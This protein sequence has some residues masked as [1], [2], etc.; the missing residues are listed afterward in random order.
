MVVSI[1]LNSILIN[2]NTI[3]DINSSGALID[4][5][6]STATVDYW[7]YVAVGTGVVVGVAA[8]CV[9]ISTLYVKP[10]VTDTTD[11]AV[12]LARANAEVNR[13]MR[14]AAESGRPVK[15]MENIDQN[16]LSLK[17]NFQNYGERLIYDSFPSVDPETMNH[18]REYILYNELFTGIH[19]ELFNMCHI[20]GA[21]TMVYC[22]IMNNTLI[23][24][25]DASHT[26]L[27]PFL[28][29]GAESVVESAQRMEELKVFTGLTLEQLQS[30]HGSAFTYNDIVLKKE[31][32][33]ELR[34]RTRFD[35]TLFLRQLLCYSPELRYIDWLNLEVTTR[36]A[37]PGFSDSIYA[38]SLP[39]LEQLIAQKSGQFSSFMSYRL[40]S[41]SS[42]SFG[43]P[44]S[45]EYAQKFKQALYL[46]ACKPPK[47]SLYRWLKTLELCK[48]LF[49]ATYR[50]EVG[51]K[52]ILED[53][54]DYV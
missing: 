46:D 3:V 17:Q 36:I 40:P 16:I 1:F 48:L 44:E 2:Y 21:N 26:F 30:R 12:F 19:N 11:P 41:T 4:S 45:V 27:L 6:Q 14:E 33:E 29:Q 52:Q 32:L 8:I 38:Q 13:M 15:S 42:T 54:T 25:N 22:S 28:L 39:D 23:F 7:P 10:G 51:G 9:V 50:R 34:M 37:Q 49:P 20:Y 35:H 47:I 53:V 24:M 43:I 5:V 18:C 31:M